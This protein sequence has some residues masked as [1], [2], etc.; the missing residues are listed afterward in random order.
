M[1]ISS[2][3]FVSILFAGFAELIL[4]VVLL[5]VLCLKKKISV[6]PMFLGMAAFFVSQVCIR[7]PILQILGVQSWFKAFALNYTL[8][9][10]IIL[11]FTAGLFEESARY[12]CAGCFLKKNR[13]FRD[14]ISFGLGHG[15]C[16][17]ITITGMMQINN[18]TYAIMIN[19]GTFQK[20]F[21]AVPAAQ[22]QQILNQMLNAKPELLYISVLERIFTVAFHI[23]ASVLIFKAVNDHQTRYYFY[24]LAA[25]FVTDFGS[26]ALSTYTKS[27]WISECFVM[28]VAIASVILIFRL[29][30]SFPSRT[31]EEQNIPASIS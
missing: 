22:T 15:L 2:A 1:K 11:A 9:Y 30:P 4:P 23:F 26:A 8:P 6:K 27:I 17:V 18:L 14:A 7:L 12:L 5:L 3:V 29:R 28:L 21:A 13:L 31:P 20:A 10:I 24:A 19:N 25:H 16:E